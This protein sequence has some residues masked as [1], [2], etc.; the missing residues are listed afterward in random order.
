MDESTP[1]LQN[2]NHHLPQHRLLVIFPA[3]ALIQFTSFLDQTAIAT[4]LPAISSALNTGASISLVGA[5]FLIT[6]TS[7]QLIN[8]RLSDI[9]GRKL[10]LA[11]ALTI[12][13]LGNLFSG[14]CQ[15][16]MQLFASRAF[17]GL[18]AGAINALV[19]IAIA[20]ITTL[21]QRGYY[22]G[23]IGTAVAF[24]NGLG[25]VIGGL[26]TESVGWQWSFWFVCPLCAVAV[27]YLLLVW[28]SSKNTSSSEKTFDKLKLVDWPGAWL[29]LAAISLFLIPV[30]QGGSGLAWNSPILIA[31]LVASAVL[32]GTFFVVEFRWA[33]LPMLPKHLFGYGR[34]TNILILGNILIGW[35]FWGNL[36]ITPLYLQNIRAYSPGQAGLFILPMVVAHGL[37]SALTGIIISACGRYKVVIVT[38]AVSW[39]IAAVVKLHYNQHTPMWLFMIVCVFDGVGVGCSLQPVLIGLFAGSDT[40]DRAVL[41]GLRNFIRDMGGAVGTTGKK[42]H[43]V[44]QLAPKFSPGLIAQLTS[45]VFALKDLN[46]SEEQVQMISN[47]YMDGIHGVFLSYSALIAVYL[48]ACLFIEDYGLK[49]NKR[50]SGEQNGDSN[51]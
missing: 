24:G 33:K 29:S 42:S 44:I 3:L 35:I 25:P 6:S 14:F 43:P 19:Q 4:S 50:D 28:P 8:G 18:G 5:S 46:L 10:C 16:P 23:I 51:N 17:T 32:F 1:L 22:F 48:C 30:S 27:I 26:L 7:I 47:S 39:A 2:Q 41:T 49:T 9:F 31:M 36:F 40:K 12:M 13:G 37:T 38:G 21:E 15:T 45:S 20:D 34:S 11:T